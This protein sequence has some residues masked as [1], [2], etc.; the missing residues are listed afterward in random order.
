LKNKNGEWLPNPKGISDN[1]P[2]TDEGP[3]MENEGQSG[4]QDDKTLEDIADSI[5][6]NSL[7]VQNDMDIFSTLEDLPVPA[8]TRLKKLSWKDSMNLKF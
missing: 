1:L 3:P 8:G 5:A 6:A 4:S 7:V 2:R